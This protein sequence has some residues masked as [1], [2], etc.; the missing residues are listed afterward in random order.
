MADISLKYG[1]CQMVQVTLM[2]VYEIEWLYN[3]TAAKVL[4][5]KVF[6]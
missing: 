6:L 2:S 4:L 3:I 1:N 5:P